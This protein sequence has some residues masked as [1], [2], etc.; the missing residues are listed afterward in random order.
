MNV[1]SHCD[2]LQIK[3]ILQLSEQEW[4]CAGCQSAK[5]AV[6]STVKIGSM[7]G[8]RA[9][10]AAPSNMAVVE[11]YVLPAEIRGLLE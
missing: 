9:G 11:R 3:G 10:D 5:L 2:V 4:L 7:L 8:K 1:S 6:G